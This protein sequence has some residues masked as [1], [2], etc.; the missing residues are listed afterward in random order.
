VGGQKKGEFLIVA[1]APE[2]LV[3]LKLSYGVKAYRKESNI[4]N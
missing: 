2:L 4:H 3:F 1:L